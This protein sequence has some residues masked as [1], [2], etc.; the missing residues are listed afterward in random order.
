MQN[1]NIELET[2]ATGILS[3]SLI[4]PNK[5]SPWGTVVSPGVLATNHQHLFSLRID[6]M[7]GGHENTVFQ[8]DSL[9]MEQ[10]DGDN[11]HG[12]AW[13]VVKT[14]IVTSCFTDASPFTNRVFKISNESFCNPISGNPIAYK[15][16]PQPCQLLLAAKDSV[17]RRRARFAEHH[18]WVTKYYDGDF[19]AA[20]KWSNQSLAEV[21]GL[22]DMAARKENVRD[23]D[24]VVWLTFGM[25]H[26]PRVEDFPV[27]P[28]EIITVALKPTD[29]F[30]KNPA[31]D[32]PRSI[33]A[34]NK[35]VLVQSPLVGAEM[36][37]GRCCGSGKDSPKL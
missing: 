29:F 23:E 17:V 21:G 9:S 15:I 33:Q 7:I 36:R 26:N 28:S 32:V 2:R 10:N 3:T 20:G 27:M 14:P 5:T 4:D 8:E 16:V 35:S 18:F 30:N 13:R 12:N 11:P 6:P 37:L 19:W 22:Y 31:I 1:G 24:I 34:F 25:T